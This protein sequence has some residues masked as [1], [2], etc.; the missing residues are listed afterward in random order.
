VTGR[1]FDT[2]SKEQ[3]LHPTAYDPQVQNSI[4]ALIEASDGP[5]SLR[6]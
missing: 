2:N 4:L 1:Y 3:K 6:S 5:S